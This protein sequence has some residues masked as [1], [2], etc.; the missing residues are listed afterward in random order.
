MA[1]SAHTRPRFL[2]A[3]GIC[4]PV[5]Y[6]LVV[7]ILGALTPGYSQAAQLMSEL[8]ESGAPYALAMNI[9]GFLLVS[10]SC[11]CSS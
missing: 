2:A 6:A 5:L 11:G 3:C 9:G 10:S 1:R 7:L 8:G 4:G